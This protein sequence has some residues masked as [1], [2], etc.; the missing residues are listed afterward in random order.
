MTKVILRFAEMESLFIKANEL[1]KEITGYIVFTKDSFNKEYTEESRTYKVSSDNKAFQPEKGGYSIFASCLDG[2][3]P[4]L[5]LDG[6]MRGDNAWKIE[7]CYVYQDT[8]ISI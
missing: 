6:Y 2:T 1:G 3:D 7:Y 5:R 8:Y 4:C